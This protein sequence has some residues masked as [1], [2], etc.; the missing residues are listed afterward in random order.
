M[1]PKDEGVMMD[2]RFHWDAPSAIYLRCDS[3]RELIEV[4][5]GQSIES[6]TSDAAQHVCRESEDEE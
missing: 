1:S 3:C 6:L 4:N 5:Y 2:L